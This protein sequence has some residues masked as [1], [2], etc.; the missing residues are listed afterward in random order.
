MSNSLLTPPSLTRLRTERT[1]PRF[2]RFTAS[3]TISFAKRLSLYLKVGIPLLDSL[4]R[5]RAGTHHPHSS[6]MLA[7]LLSE[8]A[9]GKPLSI[10]LDRFKGQF[11]ELAISLVRIGE[12]SGTLHRMLLYFAQIQERRV[13]LRRKLLGALIYPAIIVL[14]TFGIAGFLTLYAFPKILPLFRGFG[15]TLP[16]STRILIVISDAVSRFGIYLLIS[17]L[18]LAVIVAFLLRRPSFKARCERVI[19]GTPLLGRMVRA[20]TISILSRTLATLLASGTHIAPS[21]QLAAITS[22]SVLYRY[23]LQEAHTSILSGHPLTYPFRQQNHLFP[24]VFV[25]L[26]ETGEATGSLPEAFETLA[27]EYEQELENVSQ[28][29]TTLIEPVLMISMGLIVGF[30]ALAIITPIYQITQDMNL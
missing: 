27:L 6:A 28:N 9:A 10:A 20:Y 26:V 22:E 21:L 18:L 15:T 2:F 8:I 11:G 5:M 7:F 30:V 17:L 12:A 23:H 25:E 1:A 4:E 16:T 3:A 14:S 24:Q 29:L 19:L 13:A